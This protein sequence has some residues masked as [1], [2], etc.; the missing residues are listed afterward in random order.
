MERDYDHIA[1]EER[2]MKDWIDNKVWSMPET[3]RK[4][5]RYTVTMYPYPS[6]DMHMGHVE[7]FTIHD[8]IA[9]YYRMRGYDVLSP[10]G[11]DSFGL[12]AENAAIQRGLDP[13]EWTYANIEK[14]YSSAQR[15]GC[16]FDWDRKIATSDPEYYKWN[17]WFFLKFYE[18]GLAY[19]KAAAANWCPNDKTVL[20]NEQVV[21]GKCE[22]CGAEVTKVFMTQWF[23]KVTDYADRLLD[24]MPLNTGWNERLKTLQVNWIGR[25]FGAEVEFDVEG[26]D[27]ITVYTTRPD[28]LWGATFFVMA[29]ELP[30]AEELVKGTG[31]EQELTDFKN[32]VAKLT[33][34]DRTSTERP[35]KGMF[36]GR[37]A[38]NPVNGEK[39][40][41]WVADYVLM[42]YGTGAIMAVPAHD[43]RDLD[44]ARQYDLPVRVVIQPPDRELDEDTMTEAYVGPGTMVNSGPFDGTSVDESVKKVTDWLASEGRGRHAKNFRLRDWLVSRQRYWGTPIPIVF[45][46]D[47]GEVPVPYEELPLVLPENVD[48]TPT[49]EA[50][51]LAT[52]TDWVNVACPKCG[53]PA[54]R[55][56]DTM[57]T[58]VDSSWYFHRY[59]DPH[60]TE[61]PFERAK[62]DAWMPMDQYTGGI[63][64][65]V[66]HLIYA[67]FFQKVLV[68]MGMARDPEPFP[69]LLNQGLITMGGKRMSKSRGNIVEPQEA[70]Q[71]FGADSLRLFMLFSGPPEANFDWPEEGVDAIG[72]VAYDW[73]K[74]VWRLCEENR[75]GFDGGGTEAGPA[76]ETLR[77]DL[78]RTIKVVTA[79]YEAFSFNTAIARL[80]EL[81]NQAYR[82]RSGG[83]T[84]QQVLDEV[85][86]VLLKLLAPIAPYLAEEQWHRLGHETSI[87]FEPWPEHDPQLATEEEVTMVVQVNGKVRDTILVPADVT[88]AKMTELALAS[89]KVQGFLNGEPK[90]VIVKP[91][92][93]VSLVA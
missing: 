73:L 17:Q 39:I 41:I 71:R 25:S 53:K 76:E 68:D 4:E 63:E 18:R 44:F 1:I 45:C 33:E 34:I 5:K 66:L 55:E 28:T 50:S 69:N 8:A 24:D 57:D 38:I 75:D 6:G 65:A 61:I 26:A 85:I 14:L 83:G 93:L 37:Y 22:R 46:D 78:H 70:F 74:R 91:P 40:P 64:H 54:R 60:N 48:F 49:G 43:Q 86:E 20:A 52:A 29:P 7:I 15:I 87:H 88:E 56:T 82:Y 13:K 58:F 16:S 90:K 30:L 42:D 12:P 51:P 23:F 31:K 80:H 19:R 11:F 3:P 89:E 36:L 27:P 35:K 67:R 77:K 59:T 81:V 10:I 62:S 72:P 47:C 79:D 9:R 32:Q 92:K 21:A 84:N 2:W